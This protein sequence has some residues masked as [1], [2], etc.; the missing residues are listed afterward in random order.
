M[1]ASHLLALCFVLTVYGADLG[2]TLGFSS[3]STTEVPTHVSNDA[4]HAKLID[5]LTGLTDRP[6]RP[7]NYPQAAS[8]PLVRLATSPRSGDGPKKD[9]NPEIWTP[10]QK[11]MWILF[12]KNTHVDNVCRNGPELFYTMT[13]TCSTPTRIICMPS[14]CNWNAVHHSKIPI[15]IF[16]ELLQVLLLST[17]VCVLGLTKAFDTLTDV[18]I[19]C[20]ELLLVFLA[21]F[22]TPGVAVTQAPADQS[23]IHNNINASTSMVTVDAVASWAQLVTACAAPSASITLSP[24]FQMGVY[25]NEIDFSGKVIVIFGS[26]ATLDAGQKGRFFNGYGRIGKFSSLELHDITLQN[27]ETPGTYH[28]WGG[29]ILAE[30]GAN[31]GLEIHNVIFENCAADYGGAIFVR[32]GVDVKIYGSKFKTNSA[33]TVGGAIYAENCTAVAIYTCVF[34][35]NEAA[36]GGAVALSSAN[37]GFHGGNFIAGNNKTRGHNDVARYDANSHVTFACATGKEGTPIKMVAGELMPPLPPASLKCSSPYLCHVTTQ[38]CIPAAVGD[39]LQV[40]RSGCGLPP[41]PQRRAQEKQALELFAKATT[42]PSSDGWVRSCQAGWKDSSTDVCDRHGVTCEPASNGY[43]IGIELS[44]CGLTGTIPS[45]T[46]FALQGLKE[47]H[48][49]S[50]AYKGLPGLQ[51]HLPSDLSSCT[52]LEVID[53]NSN[54]L[55]GTMPSLAALVNLKTVDVHYNKFSGH[56]PTIAF[57]PINYISFASNAFTGTIPSG[58]SAL[59]NIQ[60]LGLANNK[61]SGTTGI[62]TKFPR[63]QVVFLR[64]NSFVGEIPRLPNSTAVADFDHNKFSSIAPDACRP[65]APLAFSHPCGCVSNYPS[66]P[67]GTCCFANNSFSRPLT[68]CL[69]YCF[70][71]QA[72]SH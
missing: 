68:P 15:F 23:S 19:P 9:A 45:N 56:L 21:L 44:S 71:D 20:W 55:D 29:A 34:E 42:S 18:K 3:T 8:A 24:T 28:P 27:G 14:H 5:G 13:H 53:F 7:R 12:A 11:R 41:D 65:S 64:N 31:I 26:N 67:F 1:T 39:P 52:S 54:N 63:L 58:W 47:I 40:C 35:S 51:G 36:W 61:L 33:I 25:N 46:I 70:S 43:V 30:N 60:V 6:D 4:I 48:L 22:P 49:R 16:C 2:R 37:V 69:Q 50:E 57:S 38:T 17:A 66:Q 72:C 59:T 62:V 10:G 32:L